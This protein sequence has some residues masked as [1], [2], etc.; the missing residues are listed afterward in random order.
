[1]QIDKFNNW[2]ILATFEVQSLNKTQVIRNFRVFMIRTPQ[3]YIKIGV[4]KKALQTMKATLTESSML[5]SLN[6]NY[7]WGKKNHTTL[8]PPA[9]AI[10]TYQLMEYCGNL[11][12]ISQKL[13]PK[14]AKNVIFTKTSY[15]SKSEIKF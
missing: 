12:D 9:G 11:V 7:L 8:C 6:Y 15:W 5:H 14:L 3:I 13:K 4:V 2:R 1:M 10:S